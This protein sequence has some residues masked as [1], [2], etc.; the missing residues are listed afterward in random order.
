MMRNPL[1]AWVL[2]LGLLA[3]CGEAP[4]GAAPTGAAE[5]PGTAAVAPPDDMPAPAA[6]AEGAGADAPKAEAAAGGAVLPSPETIKS[7]AYT[8]LSRP[9]FIYVNKKSLATKPEVALYV[10]HF[11][12]DGQ[13]AVSEVGY[14]P[15]AEEDLK[16]SR[17]ALAEAG[18]TAAPAGEVAGKVVIDGSSTV[19]PLSAA[20]AKQVEEKTSKNVMVEVGRSG[21]GGGFKK[22]VIGETDIS[23]ASRPIDAKEVEAAAKGG[24]EYIGVKVA[25]DGICVVVSQENDWVDSIS[26]AD[27]K[28]MWEPNSAAK[29]WKD[30]NPAWPD[31]ELQLYGADSDS[32]TFDFFTEVIN[33]KSKQSRTEYTASGDDN[34]LVTGVRDNKYA[35]GYIPFAYFEENKDSLKLLGVIPA[36]KKE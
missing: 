3:G 33:G 35:L 28:K 20:I 12:N 15:L 17:T 8:P 2:G 26:V 24:I 18:V 16:A 31:K 9:L 4:R 13:S 34:V 6:T 25:I 36:A 5:A 29:T 30:V 27:L 10:H 1:A 21:T 22:F 19:F 23:G 11:L 7:G 32:G 14:V